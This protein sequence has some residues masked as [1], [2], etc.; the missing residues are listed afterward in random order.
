MANNIIKVIYWNGTSYQVSKPTITGATIHQFKLCAITKK[1]TYNKMYCINNAGTTII[2]YDV[3]RNGAGLPTG[4]T[5]SLETSAIYSVNFLSDSDFKY[6]PD[7]D[8]AI[9]I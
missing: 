9:M 8:T 2:E 1:P 5:K 4:F 7:W 3:T 6:Y